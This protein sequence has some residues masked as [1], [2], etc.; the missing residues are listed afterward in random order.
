MASLQCRKVAAALTV[1]LVI[2]YMWDVARRRGHR[3]T[4]LAG[5]QH[6]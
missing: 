1:V 2:A 4:I 5:A 3:R 6:L